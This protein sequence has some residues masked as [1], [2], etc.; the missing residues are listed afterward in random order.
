MPENFL[1][2]SESVELVNLAIDKLEQGRQEQ[3]GIGEI[4]S[5]WCNFVKTNLYNSVPYKRQYIGRS[6]KRH[7]P[8]KP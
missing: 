8:A 7:K 6:A 5:S 2:S 3:Q 1:L 4:Y